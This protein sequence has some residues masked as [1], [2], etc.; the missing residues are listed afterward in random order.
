MMSENTLDIAVHP[1]FLY[2]SLG[3]MIVFIILH[4]YS[5]KR[6]KL[7]PGKIFLLYMLTY[8]A[9]RVVIEDLRTD[10][11]VIPGTH[12]RV[13]QILGIFLVATSSI[14]L[15]INKKKHLPN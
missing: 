8:S 7:Y 6:S 15:I 14:L 11:L 4:M 2:E 13:S 1:C 3:C 9:I 5:Y 10:S 12:L